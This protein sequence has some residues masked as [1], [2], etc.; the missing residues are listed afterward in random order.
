MVVWGYARLVGFD[1]DYN[2]KPDILESYAVEDD[3]VF[4]FHLRDGHRWSDGNPFTTE[5]IRYWWEDVANHK[6]LSPQA[7]PR[8]MLANERP[9]TV[10]IIDETTVALHMADPNP[11]FLN[12]LAAARPPFIY[13]PAHYMKQFHARYTDIEKLQYL[14]AEKGAR[15]WAQLHNKLDNLYKNDN[16]KLPTLQPWMNTT[17]KKAA[18]LRD[19]AQSLLPPL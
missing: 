14:I 12:L 9:P 4:T 5:D 7:P 3:R 8:Y 19:A 11:E 1:S 2:L 17:G 15:N 6:D 18:A 16:K 13:R 10:E